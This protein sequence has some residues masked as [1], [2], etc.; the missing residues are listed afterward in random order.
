MA[1]PV[2]RFLRQRRPAWERLEGLLERLGRQGLSS[3]SPEELDEFARL[4]RQAA[5]DL[6]YAQ[7]HY[8]FHQEVNYYL[9]HL[10]ARAHGH[11]YA[12]QRQGLASVVWFLREGFPLLVRRRRGYILVA[13]GVFL[14]SGGF[15]FAAGWRGTE[16]AEVLVP[17]AMREWLETTRY[18]PGTGLM[19]PALRPLLGSTILV[20]NLQVGLLAFAWGLLLGIGTLYILLQNGLV[21]GAL[22]GLMHQGASSQH[23]LLLWSLL[24][25][26]G[27]IELPAIFICGG[28]GLMLGDALLRPGEH[29]RLH[30]LVQMGKE[31]VQLVGGAALMFAV[32]ALIEAFLTP[33]AL[34]PA[35]KLGAATL[36][37][38][39]LLVY[40]GSAFL[41]SKP[42]GGNSLGEETSGTSQML[43]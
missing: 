41:S 31:A 28:A 39:L 40:L 36:A 19:P 4:Y 38:A 30:R 22:I 13:A 35:A 33:S 2:E 32:A 14:I 11:F 21:I 15:A 8:P 24:L 7:A 37:G 43:R 23:I 12:P 20:N 17:E 18:R 6:A 1:L 9:N 10:V 25:P 16:L 3:L 29:P 34:S 42:T 27:V 26:H 5:A